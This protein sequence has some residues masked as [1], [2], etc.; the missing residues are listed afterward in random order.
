MIE[1]VIKYKFAGVIFFDVSAVSLW[2][3]KNNERKQMTLAPN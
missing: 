2:V 1:Y 3:T